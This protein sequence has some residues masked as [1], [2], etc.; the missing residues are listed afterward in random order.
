MIGLKRSAA[1]AAIALAAGEAALVD[2]GQVRTTRAPMLVDQLDQEQWRSLLASLKG[3]SRAREL[4]VTVALPA[5]AAPLRAY[6]QPPDSPDWQRAVAAELVQEAIPAVVSGGHRSGP[7]WVC[8][9]ALDTLRNLDAACR[10]SGLRLEAVEPAA[11]S[12]LRLAPTPGGTTVVV[13]AGS[14]GCEIAAGQAGIP[15]LAR[16]AAARRPDDIAAEV[17]L[18]VRYLE[19]EGAHVTSVVLLGPVAEAVAEVLRG[20]DIKLAEAVHFDSAAAAVAT[21]ASRRPRGRAADFLP[22]LSG[23]TSRT[24]RAA[25]PAAA[26]LLVASVVHAANQTSAADALR[27]QVATLGAQQDQLQAR[28]RLWTGPAAEAARKAMSRLEQERVPVQFLDRLRDLVPD[29]LWIEQVEARSNSVT[30]RGKSLSRESVLSF[31]RSFHTAWPG[32]VLARVDL[33]TDQKPGAFY[34]FTVQ[35]SSQQLAPRTPARPPEEG[36]AR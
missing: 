33:V 27:T 12:L 34:A 30:I 29:D 32:A 35:A 31:A 13:A 15:T 28:L 26:L 19:R 36:D 2:H 18:T 8:A 16:S 3:E 17:E 10:A 5:Q 14:S 6:R 9:T 22:A 1:G 23:R 24:A 20:K 11:L 7:V 21:G 25:A 4:L